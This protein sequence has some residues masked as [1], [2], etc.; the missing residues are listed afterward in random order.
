MTAPEDRA[1]SEFRIAGRT[2]TGTVLR[3][4]DSAT[5]PLRDG[6]MVRERFTA[7]AF[8]PVP[9]VP[10]VMQH[11]ESLVIAKGGEYILSDGPRALSVRA[12]L[13]A[14]SAAL[15]LVRAGALRGYS[16]RFWPLVQAFENGERVVSKARLGHVG[17]VADAAY[18]QSKAEIRAKSG[19]TLRSRVPYSKR[20]ACECIARAGP[21][22]GGACVPYARFAKVAGDEM[23]AAIREAVEEARDVLAV[24]RDY[25]RVRSAPL[26]VARCGPREH[27]RRARSRSGSPD[28][29]S[30][31]LG[32]VGVRIGRDHRAPAD[33]L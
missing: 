8:A 20:L 13:R 28:W 30:R 9:D 12:E 4:G 32:G 19:R 1:G 11:D 29:R 5:V 14:D 25:S 2:L 6:R 31:R 24:F 10:L 7:G 26:D 21:G 15:D 16:F 17:L 3:Y 23:E 33:R 27:G 22:S 18:P